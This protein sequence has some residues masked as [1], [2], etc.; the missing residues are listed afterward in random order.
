MDDTRTT[1]RK[2]TFLGYLVETV[3][4]NFPE[5][6]NFYEELNLDGATQ[7]AVLLNQYT[8]FWITPFT[9][10]AVIEYFGFIQIWIFERV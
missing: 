1:D 2:Q 7:G 4:R 9:E 5:I 3:R 10:D 8:Y 6:S